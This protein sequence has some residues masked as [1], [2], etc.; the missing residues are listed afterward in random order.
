AALVLGAGGLLAG[1][2]VGWVLI[3]L[4]GLAMIVSAGI[5]AFHVGV[6]QKWWAG[7]T[8]CSGGSLAGLDP[9]EAMKRLMETPVVRCDEVPWSLFGISMAGWNMIVSGVAGI[10]LAAGASLRLVRAPQ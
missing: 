8:G 2:R 9:A 10:L 6:E 3:A 7:P 5:G 4:A 1:G